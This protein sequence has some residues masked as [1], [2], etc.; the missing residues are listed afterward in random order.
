MAA[1]YVHLLLVLLVGAPLAPAQTD[2]EPGPEA[3]LD[4]VLSSTLRAGDASLPE[5]VVVPEDAAS[6]PSPAPSDLAVEDGDAAAPPQLRKPSADKAWSLAERRE[7]LMADLD[8]GEPIYPRVATP[9]LVAHARVAGPG[10]SLRADSAERCLQLC[11]LR[12]HS[13][14]AANYHAAT[15]K[16]RLLARCAPTKVA[17]E[18][19]DYHHFA[20]RPHVR[21]DGFSH[22]P[23]SGS[24]MK[25][26]SQ[27]ADYAGA[28][29]LCELQGGRLAALTSPALNEYAASLLR[30]AG[31]QYA[32]IGLRDV[33]GREGDPT[34]SDGTS[35]SE[36]RFFKPAPQHWRNATD[37]NCWAL[38]DDGHWA[39]LS[40]KT[41]RLYGVCEVPLF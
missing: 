1:C 12:P 7:Q 2:S 24:C 20:A 28:D 34:H 15:H 14:D 25:V 23:N 18:H 41:R 39:E 30:Q 3:P 32:W 38:R 36:R 6:Q 11:R 29:R 22:E 13:C 17:Y 21:G 35:V 9:R 26:V 4:V 16:C 27:Q 37:K 33:Y 10:T 19:H 5:Y 40:C 31:A 8:D